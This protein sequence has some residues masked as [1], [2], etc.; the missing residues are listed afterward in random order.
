MNRYTLV[1]ERKAWIPPHHYKLMYPCDEPPSFVDTRHAFASLDDLWGQPLEYPG[2]GLV[3]AIASILHFHDPN[4]IPSRLFLS[5]H[6][7]VIAGD[8]LG[9]DLTVS[10]GVYAFLQY[11]VCQEMVW[12]SIPS[13][14]H[15][16]PSQQAH[17]LARS[18]RTYDFRHLRQDMLM[19]KF[20]LASHAVFLVGIRVYSSL[21][22]YLSRIPSIPSQRS[23][24][25]PCPDRSNETWLGGHALCCIGYDDD[26]HVFFTRSS[27]GYHS[28]PYAYLTDRELTSDLWLLERF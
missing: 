13:K 27:W 23:G 5:Y 22:D 24:P 11:G 12:P 21:H 1:I 4:L 8:Q 19:M 3:D 18:R 14:F 15:I 10:H 17:C 28:F 7:R 6:Q 26:E 25:V 20:A 16:A 2:S 9:S